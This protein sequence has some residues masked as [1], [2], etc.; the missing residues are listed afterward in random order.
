M[1]ARREGAVVV[2][3]WSP[4]NVP[5]RRGAAEAGG[6]DRAPRPGNP[7]AEGVSLPRW[8]ALAFLAL[9]YSGGLP[10]LAAVSPYLLYGGYAVLA[11]CVCL[12][13]LPRPVALNRVLC[14]RAYLL[15]ILFYVVWGTAFSWDPGLVLP[16]GG[17]VLVR[18]AFL[19][20]AFVLT[21]GRRRHL[22]ALARLIGLTAVVNFGICAYEA[23]NPSLIEDLARVLNP[24]ATAFNVFRPAG[25]WSNPNEAAFAF[26]F[27][28]LLSRW[29]RGLC[30]W[31]AR[32]AA[33]AG[34]YLTAS[35]TGLYLVVGCGT[36]YGLF[37]LR[38]LAR[39]ARRAAVVLNV[40]WVAGLG[41]VVLL[42]VL[43]LQFD[44]SDNY[45]TRRVLDYSEASTRGAGGESRAELA[46]Q[47]LDAA[48]NGPWHGYGLFTFQDL[49]GSG[50]YSVTSTGTH[51]VYLAVFGEVGLVG[52]CVYLAVL[53]LG[54]LRLVTCRAVPEDLFP[55]AL[56][57][58]SYLIIGVAWHNQ[59]ISLS[60]MIYVALLYHLPGL[61][62]RPPLARGSRPA[63]SP[64][65]VANVRVRCA[66]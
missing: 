52:L 2:E 16:E 32:L 48:L 59:L 34:I 9:V 27:A 49:A 11:A 35:R 29:D 13:V 17:R 45:I 20:G 33:L 8:V 15:W 14:L 64:I 47:A 37:K 23:L 36:L 39:D 61:L 58:G 65:G 63:P 51:N 4:G 53:G 7:G 21:V 6:R 42:L 40:A 18:N 50:V 38:A 44:V 46:A 1:T 25:L 19:T 60:G 43:P 41:L 22:A 57:W 10:F 28:L 12:C 30:A 5:S 66:V 56:L 3:G 54:L 31:L 26:L 55:T 24:D 62:G